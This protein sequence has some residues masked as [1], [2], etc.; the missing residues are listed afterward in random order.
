MG[1]VSE[2]LFVGAFCGILVYHVM[3]IHENKRGVKEF[4]SH[5]HAAD[6]SIDGIRGWY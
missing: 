5:T 2:A 3:T 6:G 4:K 1:L